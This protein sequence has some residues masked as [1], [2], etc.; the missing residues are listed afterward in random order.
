MVYPN[1]EERFYPQNKELAAR[2]IAGGLE[3]AVIAR[4]SLENVR[5][6]AQMAGREL[7]EVQGNE[8]YIIL[9]FQ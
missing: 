9:R 7:V 5:E 6:L 1:L 3:Y 2:A 4:E 8:R